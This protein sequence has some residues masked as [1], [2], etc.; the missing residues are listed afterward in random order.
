MEFCRTVIL[1]GSV[2]ALSAGADSALARDRLGDSYSIMAPEPW[3]APRHQ[4]PRGIP[5]EPNAARPR[6]VPQ[7]TPR[8]ARPAPPVV[9]PNGQ[10]I[11]NLPPVNQGIVPGGGRETFGDRALRCS[12]QAGVY[13]VPGDQRSVYMHSCTQ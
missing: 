11:P 12:H 13:G 8:V 2:L 6:P 3:L 10:V 5:R 1:L 4:S 7:P 9:L